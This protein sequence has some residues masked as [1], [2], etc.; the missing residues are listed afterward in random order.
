MLA[1]PRGPFLRVVVAHAVVA[2]AALAPLSASAVEC[3]DV[4]TQDTTLTADLTCGPGQ[5]ALIIG[6]SNITLDLGGYTISGPFTGSLQT[7]GIGVLVASPYTN[8]TIRNGTIR[9]F[10]IGVRLDTT[11]GNTVRN[12]TLVQNVRGVDVANANN[13][14]IEKNRIE[15]SGLDAIRLGGVSSGNVVRQ[16]TLTGNVFG[17]SV[18]DDTSNNT[19]TQNTVTGG[20]AFGIAVFT[21]GTG[22]VVSR[23]IVSGTGQDGIVVSAGSQNTLV[24]QNTVSLS[25]RDGISVG[26]TTVGTR[27]LQNTV[28]QN[29]DDGIDVESAATTITKNTATSNGDLGIEA[30]PGV[31]DGGGNKASGNGN[32]L[33]CVGVVCTPV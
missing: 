24:S 14:I 3:G 10:G 21:S 11:S 13:N 26:A 9:G 4:I 23:N 12:L 17:I 6:A 27:V 19:V 25:G 28:F 5:T 20:G 16:N 29:S 15:G 8:V 2:L 7:G 32:P 22:N 18:T 30:V 33:Q 31:T 1:A